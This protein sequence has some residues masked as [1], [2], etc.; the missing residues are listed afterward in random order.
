MPRGRREDDR[1]RH[2]WPEARHRAGQKFVKIRVRSTRVPR[3]GDKVAA[4]LGHKGTAGAMHRREDVL[5]T[6]GRRMVSHGAA[7]PW[8][9]LDDA[10]EAC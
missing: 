8:R 6:A 7:A 5:E 3:S 1:E 2:H 10:R 9:G 4:R